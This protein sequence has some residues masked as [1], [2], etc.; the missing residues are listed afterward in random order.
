MHIAVIED[1]RSFHLVLGAGEIHPTGERRRL[2]LKRNTAKIEK[3]SFIR[4]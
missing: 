4:R 2:L 3:I 1:E